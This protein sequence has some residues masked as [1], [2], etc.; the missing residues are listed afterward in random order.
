RGALQEVYNQLS[1][2]NV[3]NPDKFLEYSN[4]I[5]LM[6]DGKHNMGGDPSVEVNKIRE[7]L[8]IRKNH[9]EDKLDIYVFGLGDDI[10]QDELNDI[11]SKKDKEKHVFQMKDIN[12]LKE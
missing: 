1:F 11:A 10:S 2:D 3:R 9:R 7:F 5:I 12:K 6:T 8:D 4:I